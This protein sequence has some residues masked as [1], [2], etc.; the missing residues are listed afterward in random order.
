MLVISFLVAFLTFGFFV[1]GFGL[2]I[3]WPICVIWGA[4]ATSSYNQK[5]LS[6]QH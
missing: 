1:F 4:A 3:I 6:G 5:L 2:I